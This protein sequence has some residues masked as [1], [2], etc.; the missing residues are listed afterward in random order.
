MH[1]EKRSHSLLSCFM[2]ILRYMFLG[3]LLRP[4]QPPQ[5]ASS[6]SLSKTFLMLCYIQGLLYWS[7]ILDFLVF[8]W[9]F[10]LLSHARQIFNYHGIGIIHSCLIMVQC[11]LYVGVITPCNRSVESFIPK[12]PFYINFQFCLIGFPVCFS[13]IFGKMWSRCEVIRFQSLCL[14]SKKLS[15]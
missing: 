15:S 14:C 6:I 11:S 9:L 7:H 2:C 1:Q 5:I 12:H 13:A 8:N 3:C 4:V 10:D